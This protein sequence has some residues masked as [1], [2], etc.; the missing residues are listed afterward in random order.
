MG[1][2]ER[3]T[4]LEARAVSLEELLAHQQRLLEQLNAGV[5]QLREDVDRLQAGQ[6][7][8]KQ[9]VG[10]LVEF[11]ESAEGSA[12]EKPPHY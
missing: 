11:Y 1:A 8:L 12:D 5:T 3:L 10:R 9:T 6:A 2:D 7:K 4:R